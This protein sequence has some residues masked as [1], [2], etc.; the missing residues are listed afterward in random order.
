MVDAPHAVLQDTDDGQT[1]LMLAASY[2][3]IDCL[4]LLLDANADVGLRDRRD[5]T[6]LI[7]A[8][9]VH[10]SRWHRPTAACS[11]PYRCLLTA[12][13]LP[14]HRLTAACSP[15]HRCLLTPPHP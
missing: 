13:P 14:A 8:A 7:V 12:P 1:P 2:G 11:P 15:P 6:A 5:N 10:V 9:K 4:R 3:N